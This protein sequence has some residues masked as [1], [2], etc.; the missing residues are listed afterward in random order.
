M[1]AGW[2]SVGSGRRAERALVRAMLAGDE[3]AFERF[4][5]EYAPAVY[6]TLLRRTG[7][8]E[9]ARDLAQTAIVKAIAKLPSFRGEAGLA[10]WLFACGRNELA[11]HFRKLSR[12]PA[13]VPWAEEVAHAEGR[14]GE[15][16]VPSPAPG[17]E[18]RCL[19]DERT[20]LVHQAL[21]ELPSHY[22][23][24]LEWK[25]LDG[26]PVREIARRLG[27]EEKAA[28]SLL[29]RARKAFRLGYRRQLEGLGDAGERPPSRVLVEISS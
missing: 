21:D 20:G 5:R 6:R 2:H 13:A 19:A 10:T 1:T 23:R 16:M 9:L 14:D 8:R 24:A 15:P 3:A 17:P 4:T 25:Y 29:T 26:E 27:L 7:D 11:M 12:S 18:E 28:E 22:G